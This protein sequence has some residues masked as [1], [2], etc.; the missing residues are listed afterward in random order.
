[1]RLY[2]YISE[3]SLLF[4]FPAI[5]EIIQQKLCKRIAA[6]QS[7]C[8]SAA[9]SNKVMISGGLVQVTSNDGSVLDLQAIYN[10][11]KPLYIQAEIVV[12]VVMYQFAIAKITLGMCLQGHCL[13]A[14][15]VM[16]IIQIIRY[17]ASNIHIFAYR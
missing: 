15:V 10:K 14:A 7:S 12:I 2:C 13:Y 5:E 17:Y 3:V 8:N 1:M 4:S 9:A 6:T 11:I 16:L